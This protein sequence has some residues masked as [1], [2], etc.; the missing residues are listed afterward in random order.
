MT[1]FEHI[2]VT[3]SILNLLA[4]IIFGIINAMV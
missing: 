2:M 3:I 1:D 4:V